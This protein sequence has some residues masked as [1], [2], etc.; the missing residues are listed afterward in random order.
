MSATNILI[1]DISPAINLGRELCALLEA[2]R[3]LRLRLDYRIV[4]AEELL[5]DPRNRL[6]ELVEPVD[7]AV[8]FLVASEKLLGDLKNIFLGSQELLKGLP[9]MVVSDARMPAD[10]FDLVRLGASD[11]LTPPLTATSVMPRFWRQI[12]LSGRREENLLSLSRKSPVSDHMI[13]ES[14]AFVAAVADLP[15]VAACESTV[16][17]SGET[18]TGKEI[19]ARTIHRLSRRADKPFVP[20]NCGAIPVDLVENELF[21]H[22]RGAYTTALTSSPGLIKSASS[23][24]LFLDEID[25]MPLMAQVKLLRFLQEKEYRPIGSPVSEHADVRVITATNIDIERAVSEGRIREDL[26]YRLN[27]IPITLPPLR[28]RREDILL[29]AEH[30]LQRFSSVFGKSTIG[31]SPEARQKLLLHNWPGNVRELENVIER[32]VALCHGKV[33]EGHDIHLT[34]GGR[35]EQPESFQEAKARVIEQFERTYIQSLLLT[36]DGN[37]SQAARAANKNRRAF[38]ELLR[39]YRIDAQNFVA[40]SRETLS[41]LGKR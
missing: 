17:I 3:T 38:W 13:G 32:S 22:Q 36:Y 33:L 25:S 2:D 34:H 35:G 39:K 24:T 37:I 27:I 26:Y 28:D 10:L 8:L 23:G 29:L 12:E 6:E 30:F 4:D 7:P 20:V 16:L 11:F 19:C 21:G 9:V 41:N 14:P 31:F 5:G 40:Q 1:L 18:G 15:Q